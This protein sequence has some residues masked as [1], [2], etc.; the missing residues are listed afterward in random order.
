MSTD[1]SDEK[2][3]KNNMLK[4]YQFPDESDPELLYKLFLKREFYYNK[5]PNR[6]EFNKYE[7]IKEYRDNIC[8]R[9][10]T[11]HE[12]QAM[13]SNFI[14]PDTPYRGL[15]VFHGLGTGKT[16]V[17][18]AIAEK[19][20]P[21][22]QKYNT[23]IIVLVSG[24]LIKENWK[25]H[26]LLC[27]GETYL[28][29]Q[30]K[31]VYTDEIERVRLEKN[32]LIQAMQYYRFMSYR[33][34]YKH[35]LGEKIID[36]KVV[37]G[38]KVKVSYRK[39]DEGEF[40][41]DLAVDRIY[42]LN[43]TIIIVDEAHN[44][45]G[46]A[47]GDA[48]KHII[49]NS[50]NLKVVLLSGT[51]MKNLADDIIE[52]V[53]FIRPPDMQIER[54]RIFNSEKNHT[55]EFKQNGLKYLKN[56]LRGY[57]SHVRG[58]DPLI[59]AKRVDRGEVPKGLLFTKVIKC[60]MLKLQ[61]D[62]Y[63]KAIKE[64]NDSLDRK[65][66]AVANF[67]FP[68]LSADKKEIVGS[69]GREGLQQLKN[70]L[71]SN[72]EQL[73]KKLSKLLYGRDD[74]KDMIDISSD[75]L[76][77]SGKILKGSNLKYFSTKFYT[78]INNLNKLVEG[79][80][81][82][83]TA[84]VY[85]NLV[86]VG[87]EL[88]REILIQNGYLEYQEI[89]SDYQIQSD[90]IC[91]YCGKTYSQHR[92]ISASQDGG[93]DSEQTDSKQTDSE[94]S[95]EDTNSEK[96]IKSDEEDDKKSD[97]SPKSHTFFPATF[98]S[99]TGK[100]NDEA[101]DVIPEDKKKILDN[102]FNT[103]ANK[104]GKYLKIVMGSKVM[105]E[106][107]SMRQIKDV[108][109]LDVYFNLGRVD[110]VV[111]RAIRWC[112][113]YKLMSETNM[114]PHV[115]VY[116][117]VVSVP[118]GLSSEEELY[119]KAEL[120]YLLIKKVERAMKEVAIDCPLNI[121]GNMFKE[122]IEKSK[123][124]GK[125][126]EEPCT[127]LCDYTICN[128]KC[129]DLKLN[130]EFY[131]PGRNIYKNV[132]KDKLDYSTFSHSLAQHEIDYV[133]DKIKEM[134]I[135]GF[136]Y[137]IHEILEYVRLT[138]DEEKRELFDEFFVFK[139]LDNLL[140]VS[141]ND[142]NNYY[143]AV[144]DKHNRVGY[145]IYRDQYYIFQPFDQNEDVPIYYR[146]TA[147]TKVSQKL[148]LYNYLKS[149]PYYENLKEDK[150]KNDSQ[151]DEIKQYEF[152]Y[153]YYETRDENDYVGYIDREL[154]RRKNKT[155]DEIKDVF[156]IREKRAKILEKKRAT[157]IPS[158]KG[159]VCET[160]KSVH[161]L[162]KVAESLGEKVDLKTHTRGDICGMISKKMLSMEKYSTT[163]NKDKITYIMLPTNHPSYPFPYN[164][165]DRIEY[166]K[167]KLEK[168]IKFK[169]NISVETSKHQKGEL[170]GMP[171]YQIMIADNKNLKE[172]ESMLEELGA[173]KSKE[174]WM[175]VVE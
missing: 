141:E 149:T 164:L 74:E 118:N 104:E 17:G 58:S 55:M 18:V 16:C 89:Y 152:D 12:H 172:Y 136:M 82:A 67:V 5:I 28:K 78:A 87:I 48:L 169:I 107:I 15:V 75:G 139:A 39:T 73:N 121:Q 100:S 47:Y 175:I 23:K 41:R 70:Q 119:Q 49:K 53:N 57:I 153:D 22:V 166:I 95:D 133:K 71:K 92:N 8:A 30:D 109:I 123:N 157:G 77:I 106:G 140:P 56:M 26:L 69:Y 125:D 143:D 93:A 44:L 11:L 14:N 25:Q 1:N 19:F 112:S 148:S 171:Y 120:K 170:K 31:S 54:D 3:I 90:T 110:Q 62:T 43:N 99:I 60:S 124:C 61:Q 154:S 37:K 80:R 158:I 65:S 96:D 135:I 108:H 59:F 51:P 88:F 128:Y 42:N 94:Q 144:I 134:Y 97:Y 162:K 84:F 4:E 27:T 83:G 34:F 10:F 114:F 21:L 86:K 38:E 137:T 159:A 173:K 103:I 168:Q 160:A 142:F 76:T 113:H 46:N 9:K 156:K 165:E 66:E 131:D 63:D 32:A 7:D 161:Y 36:R 45:T 150:D 20:K 101:T 163:K 117:Y 33:S 81:G 167:N 6:P 72:A 2:E 105:N 24:P 40:E 79:K 126:G 138:Y 64:Q 52:L 146:T 13:L 151:T 116:K 111:G 115:D 68:I 35:V 130:S 174:G 127:G 98:I 129:D 145:I 50:I 102:V 147:S 132:P 29:Y 91:Y 155:A 122:E 85:S